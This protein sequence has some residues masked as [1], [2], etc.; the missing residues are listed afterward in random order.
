MIIFSNASL[1]S[2]IGFYFFWKKLF[3]LESLSLKKENMIKDIRNI[4]RIKKNLN[5]TAIKEGLKLEILIPLSRS[6]FLLITISR[7]FFSRIHYPVLFFEQPQGILLISEILTF[8]I[9]TNGMRWLKHLWRYTSLHF[10]P[11]ALDCTWFYII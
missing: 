10:I 11:Y 8:S 4:F 9:N 7:N 5:Y 6:N 1:R 3:F 2:V